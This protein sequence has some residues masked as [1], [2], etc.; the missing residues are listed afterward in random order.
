M[1]DRKKMTKAPHRSAKPSHYDEEAKHYDAFNEDNSRVAN[2]TIENVLKRYK[3]KTVLD[4][5]CGTGSQVFWLEKRGYEVV[6]SDI[7]AHMLK[8]ARK[9]AK[10]EKLDITFLEGDMRTVKVGKFDAV[11]TIFN[12]I[13]HLTKS[14]FEK[15]MRNIGKNL[16]EGG[17]Y[18]FDIMNLSYLM[19]DDRITSLTIDWQKVTD[20]AKIR[21][22]QYSTIDKG[23]I[24]ASY[25]INYVQ[26]G[27]GKPKISRSEQTLQLYTLKQLKEMLQRNGFKVLEVCEIDGS[28]FDEEESDR[29]VVTARYGE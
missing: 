11:I 5:T 2:Q 28:K 1:E 27:F 20:N 7:N 4:L 24:L 22:I 23:G 10:K 6:G 12:A 8:I 26:K 3:V 9:K 21:E 17:I 18:V 16:K 19:K 15:A 13:G 25:T 29:I 14:S